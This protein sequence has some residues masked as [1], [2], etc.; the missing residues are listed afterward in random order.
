MSQVRV[1]V[2][3]LGAIS[4]TFR[5]DLDAAV[6]PQ[7]EAQVT[8]FVDK[9]L[10]PAT[11]VIYLVGCGGS[12][13]MFGAMR[14]LLERSPIP[15]VALNAD[16]FM[17][18]R[19]AAL[20]PGSVVI[21]S[22]TNGGTPETARAVRFAREAGA[23]VLLVT[24]DPDS[25]VAK[26]AEDVVLHRSVEAKQVL[27]G[28][29]AYALLRAQGV[30]DDYDE[31]LAV[32]RSCSEAFETSVRELDERLRDIAAACVDEPCVYVLGSGPLEGAAQ[33]F[34]ACYLQE[35]QTKH[36]VA[37]GSGEFL[38]GAFE[39]VD[40]TV[41]VIVLLGEDA[42]RPMGA[43]AVSFLERYNQRN[44]VVDGASLSLPGVPAR[45]RATV[46][47]F[48]MA[49]CVTARLAQHFEAF[50]GRPLSERRYMWRVEY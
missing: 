18:R 49:S 4:E 1:P 37:T 29:I 47:S 23:P 46:G 50:S 19:P 24:K 42:T 45:L 11:R 35:M 15:V 3:P 17:L 41:P 36:A 40:G 31:A 9:A 16:E 38:H 39:V 2:R 14:F 30:A 32:L 13:F 25:L 21:A 26:E 34:A 20:G 27:Q 48:V 12:L 22:S 44:H 8:A 10:S 43:R 6:T 28:L 33:T 7:I 5:A